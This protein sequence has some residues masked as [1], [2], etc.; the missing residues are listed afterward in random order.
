MER[1]SSV[2]GR[3]RRET[4]SLPGF[5]SSI[6]SRVFLLTANVA[7]FGSSVQ[8]QNTLSTVNYFISENYL[9]ILLKVIKLVVVLW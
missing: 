8:H 9:F 1:N 6:D 2:N 5:A 4:Y 3:R 7:L